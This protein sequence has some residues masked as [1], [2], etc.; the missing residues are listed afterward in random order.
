MY[1]DFYGLTERPFNLTPDPR[2]L[3]LSRNH[4]EVF[5]HLLY[6]IRQHLGFIELTGEV[7]TGKTTVLRTLLGQ[8]AD[9]AYRCAFIFNPAMSALDLLRSINREFGLPARG[10]SQAGLLQA[11]NTFLLREN[12][13]GRTVVLVID[14]AQNLEPEVLEQVRLISNLE[15]ERAKLIQ[16]VLAG[17]PEL[18]SLLD[19]PN[20]RQLRQRIAVRFHLR[21]MDGDDTGAY[22][23]HRLRV[24]GGEGKVA[25]A[26]G[27]VR[28][29]FRRSKGM[30]RLINVF[31][32]RAL[33]VG[34]TGDAREITAGHIATAV[35][36]LRREGGPG[37]SG[38]LRP[39]LPWAVSF[40]LAAVVTWLAVDRPAGAPPALPSA[41]APAPS[42]P[43]D[44]AVQKPAGGN[45]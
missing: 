35:R 34:Y 26:P 15:T 39:A 42:L 30:P 8:L 3:F 10:L 24:A 41:A 32:D 31:C 23:R 20:L 5:A 33:L 37:L 43:P 27:A 2:F 12:A 22:I 7:G 18:G 25:F 36:E 38:R 13:A 29:V 14:E 4:R 9:D 11:L 6:G 17:Q 19:R 40:L 16:I 28:A 45:R 21:P 1:S 44:L